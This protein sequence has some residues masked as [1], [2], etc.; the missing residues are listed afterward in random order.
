MEDRE[1]I[2]YWIEIIECDEKWEEDLFKWEKNILYTESR[3][4][5]IL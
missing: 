5:N 4:I 2:E 1:I 3:F